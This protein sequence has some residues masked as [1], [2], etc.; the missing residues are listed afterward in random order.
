LGSSVRSGNSY[1]FPDLTVT[2][3]S[4]DKGYVLR[5][6][7]TRAVS[8]GDMIT[9][10]S[11]PSGWSVNSM[12]TQHVRVLDMASGATP[13]DIQAYL[14]SVTITVDAGKQGNGVIFL[15]SE[16]AEDAGRHIYY[17][18]D[19]DNWY[20]YVNSA[21]INWINAYNAALDKQF[22][23]KKGYLV[24]VTSN[25]ENS[26]ISS[27][28]S[29]N[30]WTS[31]TR[32]NLSAPDVTDASGKIV[33]SAPTDAQLLNYWYW[34]SGP[35]WED[36]GKNPSQCVF[37]PKTKYSEDPLPVVTVKYNY[38]NFRLTE[39]NNSGTEYCVHYYSDGTWNDFYYYNTSVNAYI[40]E[41]S[42]IDA[43]TPA[44]MGFESSKSAAVGGIAGNGTETMPVVLVADEV[45]KYSIV[46]ANASDINN[47][48]IV[49][50]TVP[51]G[52]D[53]TVSSISSGGI[54]NSGS[55]E[56]YWNLSVTPESVATVT[57]EAKK[58][59]GA[60]NK[61]VNT[62]YVTS[63]GTLVKRTNSTYHKGEVCNVT[64]SAGTGGAV[65]NGTVQNIDYNHTA[66]S[67]VTTTPSA[68]YEF[69]SWSYPP[70]TSLKGTTQ[71]A[72]TGISNY[73]SVNILGPVAFTANFKTI[74]Y[75]IG[76]TLNGG[77]DP[78]NQTSYNVTLL[79]V[80]LT[81]ASRTGYNFLGWTG[82]NSASPQKNVSIATG[83]TGNLA[84][85]A[86]WQKITYTITYDGDGGTVPSSNPAAY[87]IE[88]AAITLAEPSRLGYDFQG[89][90]GSNGSI[91]QKTVTIPAGSTGNK[92]YRANWSIITYTI[93]YNYDSGTA[94][95]T[96]NPATYT[97]T[98]TPFSISNEPTR[99]GYEFQG[100]T[101][102]NGETP[103]KIVA[104]VPGM[105]G[106]LS[107]TAHWQKIT[108][109]ITYDHNNG[110]APSIPN[111]TTYDVET[112]TITLA[113][114]TRLG[115]A[116]TGW[117]GSNGMIPQN[118]VT[119]PVGSTEDKHYT[120]NWSIITYA[121]SYNY[122]NGTAPAIANPA[123]YTV[124]QTP[125]TFANEP[126][127]TGYLFLG[128]TGANGSTPQKIVTISSES[129]SNLNYTANWST[130][131]YTISYDYNG[132]MAPATSNKAGYK[133][134]DATFTISNQPT[135]PG[136]TFTGWTGSNGT[137]PQVAVTV[138]NGSHGDLSYTANWT[139][140]SYVI[141]YNG[142][143]GTTPAGNP[144]VYNIT[145][146]TITLAPSVRPGYTFGGWQITSDTTGVSVAT[147]I[148]IPTGT[149]GNLA[150]EAQWTKDTYT[151][152]YDY[153]G[154]TAHVT[155][156]PVIYDVED[157]PV[158]LNSPSRTGFDFDKW[159]ITS[160]TTGVTIPD[161][162]TITAGTY[163]NLKCVARWIK[164]YSVTYN[165]GLATSG[166]EA[167]DNT[168][169]NYNDP[170][171]VK[172]NEGSPLMLLSDASFIGWSFQ[173]QNSVV[174]TTAA[175]PADL[176]QPGATYNAVADTTLY[177]VWA[178]D[179]GGPNGVPDSIPDYFQFDV[180]Y[181]G[182]THTA[183]YVPVDNN[184]YNSG[185]SVTIKGNI[186]ILGKADAC[187][188]GWSET[189]TPV[190]TTV[191]A[192]PTNLKQ[193]GDVFSITANTKYYAVWAEDK[194]GP[195]GVPDSIPDYLQ[196]PVTYD[197]NT[198]SGGSVPVDINLYNNGNTVTILGNT[199]ILEKTNACFIGWSYGVHALI[200]T[201]AT[202]PSDLA[203]KDDVFTINAS[204]TLYAV[205]AEDM[206]G[207]NG[208]PD[209]VPDYLQIKLTY[210]E[211]STFPADGGAVP[212]P[213]PT[214]HTMHTPITIQGNTGGLYHTPSEMVAFAGWTKSDHHG[215]VTTAAS[216]P[217]DMLVAGDIITETNDVDL[218]AV[219][220]ED[221]NGDGIPDY[222][223][224]TITVYPVH[225][226]PETEDQG[227]P[228][229]PGYFPTK[230]A[231]KPEY[232]LVGANILHEECDMCFAIE[233]DADPH[234]DRVF[235]LNYLGALTRDQVRD[236]AGEPLA[237]SYIIPKGVS[238]YTINF[239]LSEVPDSLRGKKGAIEAVIVGGGRDTSAWLAMYDHPSYETILA[240]P[241][242]DN[243][244]RIDLGITG[245]SPHLMRSINGH[246][247]RNAHSP[248]NEM[249][250]LCVYDGVSI[251]LREPG[252]CWETQFFFMTYTD[253]IMRRSVELTSFPGVTV[254]P[255]FGTHYVNSYSDFTFTA[256]YSGDYPLKVMAT[257]FY[258]KTNVE[259]IGQDMEDGTYKYTIRQV[260]EP[261]TVTFASEP[262]SGIT[263]GEYIN[264][265]SVWA[266][267]N[268]LHIRSGIRTRVYIYS[269]SGTLYKYLDI[270]EGDT[271]ETLNRGVYVVVAGNKHYKVI[272]R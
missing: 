252:G 77:T 261:W 195:G 157:L 194:S 139:A 45:L 96:A 21:S 165:R 182:N 174:T 191:A 178:E 1:T 92:E 13:A 78:G 215:I 59:A 94:P 110:T 33:A 50:D 119:I 147:G 248:L 161:G 56:I 112:A 213:T 86:N 2:G 99:P 179:K 75:T 24:T 57:Y 205:W 264:E 109:S 65:N 130:D 118:P 262:A 140:N 4:G 267:K 108:Y 117:T 30:T 145:T 250:K 128:W 42:G 85:E 69:D 74:T 234:R 131:D 259:L 242:V 36:N 255:E 16:S 170:V 270:K 141:T 256:A 156:N 177:A 236:A 180:L 138:S 169:Y 47:T 188:I 271:W 216:K 155:S 209:S 240:K 175:I 101:G 38:S 158:T 67:G 202:I 208:V 132:G 80:N 6:M 258:S 90:T 52:L 223:E 64:F 7:F 193:G 152:A 53:V 269:M 181:D 227:D 192:I 107:Y 19:T 11:A 34:S 44:L 8:S 163:G 218:Y 207:P 266:N 233:V 134:T 231:W 124:T 217:A 253:P 268:M 70:Y 32:W 72:G 115:Y 76:Y 196:Y 62:A 211:N 27:L 20:E 201:V 203:Q 15:I 220:A 200:Q 66:A 184:L 254:T 68:G 171:T 222:N 125:L 257:S 225:K 148:T 226:W 237:N 3:A 187:F 25:A 126:T 71:P 166:I 235:T 243:T 5:I 137:T 40:V 185:N 241:Y 113:E 206:N 249:E 199:G 239:V 31:G 151:I 46:A 51:V 265:L 73:T 39:P 81:D 49:R 135:R 198:H 88:S 106:N 83:T 120:A 41:Y 91:P 28:I 103:Q 143:G 229:E 144:A 189:Q 228:N 55:R 224:S 122:D 61:I 102:S 17:C 245:G 79:P 23:N 121:I 176:I 37:Y 43:G 100:W 93:G 18:S 263:G 272:I 29:A 116:F 247:W 167:V 136:Y 133:I 9:L 123:T 54:Y 12:S 244:G 162:I 212:S 172:G 154:G 48:V 204:T 186:G 230:P 10:P 87:D 168:W 190:V 219:W 260:V 238:T 149:Y 105:T 183:G 35:E 146:P 214:L 150:C 159:V 26:F 63:D 60:A 210:H 95:L 104:V 251:W 97:I 160:D 129:A 164:L 221:L 114:P 232:D 142:H 127:R 84:Y 153:D 22:M 246:S 98:Q 197:G 82:S 58:T 111:P 14:R 89:W 173:V